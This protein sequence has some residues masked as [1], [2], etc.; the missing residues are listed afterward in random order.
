MSELTLEQLQKDYPAVELV[1]PIAVSSYETIIKRIDALEARTQTIMAFAAT[2]TV[3]IPSL[4]AGRG[5]SFRSGWFITALLLFVVALTL[6]MVS[7]LKGRIT[8]LSP[9]NLYDNDLGKGEWEFKKDTIY[10]AG[11]NFRHN[12]QLLLWRNQLVVWMS[13]IFCLEAVALAVWAAGAITNLP[14]G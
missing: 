14:P 3:A 8:V 7:R 5:L 6:G 9:K 11:I 12:N 13:L 1:Y 4:T 2:L 10:Y